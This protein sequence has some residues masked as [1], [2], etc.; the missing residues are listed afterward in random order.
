MSSSPT[1]LNRQG[2]DVGTQYRS[3]IFHHSDEQKKVA[4]A[5]KKKHAKDFED[6]IVTEITKASEF[7]KAKEEHQ[8][9]L[10]NNPYYGY[11]RAV[12]W[13]KLKKLG[14]EDKEPA[15]K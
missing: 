8:N 1:T 15:E 9:F 12:V 2:A 7:Y 3:A 10:T 14:L 4:E 11:N 13:P 5:S 6:P